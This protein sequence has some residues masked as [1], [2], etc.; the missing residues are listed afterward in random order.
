MHSGL[1]THTGWDC[2]VQ[3]SIYST[4]VWS[5]P[6]KTPVRQYVLCYYYLL[7]FDGHY[8][9]YYAV[10]QSQQQLFSGANGLFGNGMRNRSTRGEAWI[11]VQMK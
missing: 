7:G 1:H 5:V 6:H 2:P 8:V 9:M 3:Y 4:T 10:G 11:R